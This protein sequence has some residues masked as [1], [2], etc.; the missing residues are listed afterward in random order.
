MSEMIERVDTESILGDLQEHEARIKDHD[1]A[2]ANVCELAKAQAA[3]IKEL[4]RIVA[5][6][7]K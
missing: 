6:L 1:A 3:R 7:A 5:E 4:E 2:I